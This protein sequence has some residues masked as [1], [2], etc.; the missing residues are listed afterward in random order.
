M[1]PHTTATSMSPKVVKEN[2][3]EQEMVQEEVGFVAVCSLE[4]DLSAFNLSEDADDFS[5]GMYA[6]MCMYIYIYI[7]IYLYIYT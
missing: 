5:P 2:K 3:Q 1:Y 7:Y 6:Y 4:K